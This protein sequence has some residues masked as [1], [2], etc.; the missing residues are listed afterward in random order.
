MG[1]DDFTQE[2]SGQLKNY[3][4]RKKIENVSLS[5]DQWRHLAY[6][7]PGMIEYMCG[8]WKGNEVKAA[9]KLLDRVVDEGPQGIMVT[10]DKIED[11]EQV[12]EQIIEDY[13]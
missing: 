13:L 5:E 1:L 3:K 2:K 10:E 9:L 4:T 11:I 6:H 12:K 7:Y 8:S